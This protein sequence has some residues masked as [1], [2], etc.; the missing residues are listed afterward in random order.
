M[1]FN[2]TWLMAAASLAALGACSTTSAASGPAASMNR[3]ASG[4]ALDA[5]IAA[6]GGDAALSMVKEL[7][8]TGHATVTTG[9]KANEVEVRDIVRPFDFGRFSTWAKS[10]GPVKADTIQV[11][12]DRAWDVRG[13]SW[14]P[15]LGDKPKYQSD[16]V[17]FYSMMLL[18]P[19]KS[20]EATVKDLP[21]TTKGTRAVQATYMGHTAELEFDATGKLVRVSAPV[22]N[23]DGGAALTQVATL[24]GEIV[25]NGVKWPKHIVIT[26]N[27]TPYLDLEIETFDASPE[28]VVR[29]FEQSLQNLPPKGNPADGDG[30]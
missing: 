28:I 5:G 21:S 23:P 14:M 16:R 20:P 30:G 17:A 12:E 19:L 10:E 24:S 18:A 29:P 22:S 26:Q 25:S 11:E 9:G 3:P 13:P 2:R 15:M 1:A 8:W 7:Y 27:D 6:A 4:N